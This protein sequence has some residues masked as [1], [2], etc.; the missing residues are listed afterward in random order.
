MSSQSQTEGEKIKHFYWEEYKWVLSFLKPY[1]HHLTFLVL[2]GF[3]LTAGELIIPKA[4]Q[5]LIDELI[6]SGDL[7]T[8]F[9]MMA[10]VTLV[11]ALMIAATGV[12]NMQQRMIR[13]KAARD[14][15]YASFLKLRTLGFSYVEKH[16]TGAILSI[17]NTDV[18][19]VQN[20]YR[21]YF[22][23]IILNLITIVLTGAMLIYMNWFLTLIIVPCYLLYYTIGPWVERQAFI[24]L[25]KYNEDRVDL[26]KQVYETASSMQELRAYDAFDS[27]IGFFLEKFKTFNRNWIISIFY[28]HSRGSIRR[29]TVYLAVLILFWL[30]SGQVR[31]G[32]LT[33]GEFVSFFFYFFLMMFT[34]TFLVT[35]ITEQQTLMIQASRLY[36]FHQHPIDVKE[37]EDPTALLSINGRITFEHVAYGYDQD[38]PIIKGINLSIE[39]G[40]KVAIVGES[41]GGKSTLLKLIC[42]F[43]DPQ[44]GTI[45][46]DSIPVK[47]LTFAQLRQ[48]IGYVF[49]E[50]FL[51]GASVKENIRFGHP[52]AT[53]EEIIEAAK[54]AYAHE[55]IERLPQGYDTL[56]GERGYKLS[57][58]QKQRI[59]IARMFIK[60][61]SVVIL[62]EATS[63]LDNE[64]E[65]YV[66][67]AI[68]ELGKDRTTI[69]VAHRLSTVQHCDR[70][71]VIQNGQ[72]VEQG[73]YHELMARQEA[74]WRLAND[75]KKENTAHV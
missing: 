57:G 66:Q 69:I 11:I 40:E 58:G 38:T 42:R 13:E 55:F 73:S 33:A 1:K 26:E 34:L 35:N 41:G 44:H 59:A 71:V 70:I 48:H 25:K 52:G 36:A 50:C 12:K 53:D 5:Y 37:T 49:Q 43:Y 16:P 47:N 75:S 19:D 23:N 31:G 18:N 68:K 9:T 22:P 61:P 39:P 24:Y 28:A 46:L 21:K 51:F 7:K 10:G 32:Y 60:N 20:I 27:R 29:V 72:I 14:L 63:A 15:Q 45:S 30:G 54:N 67:S 62:D 65:A 8:F 17:L 64:S 74:F 6:P 2:C 4:F 56:I 3:F